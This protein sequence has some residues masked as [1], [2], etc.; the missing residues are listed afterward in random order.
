MIIKLINLEYSLNKQ[1]NQFGKQSIMKIYLLFIF[2]CLGFKQAYFS[3]DIFDVCRKGDKE[4][5]KEII[6]S[7]PKIVNETNDGGFTPLIV[8]GYRNQIEIVKILL[9]NNA[10]INAKSGE[11]SV[12][13]GACYKGEMEMVK[14]LLE[15]GAEVNTDNDLGTT[16]LMY[17]ILAGNMELIKLLLEHGAKKDVKERSGKTAIDYAKQIDNQEI[18]K[19]LNSFH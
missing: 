10:D 16:P 2:F 14:L 19:L 6:K 17:A 8:A 4:A 13:M 5:L 12:L 18:V 7:N 1:F 9:E 3:Q 15:K 11:G